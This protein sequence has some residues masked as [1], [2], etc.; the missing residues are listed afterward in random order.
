MELPLPGKIVNQKQF[1]ISGRAAEISTTVQD[2]KDAGLAHPT[3]LALTLLSS[4]CKQQIDR[5]K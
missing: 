4:Q 1:C 3:H 2:L 5:E